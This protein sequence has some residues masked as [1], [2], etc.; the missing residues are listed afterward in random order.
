LLVPLSSLRSGGI[1]WGNTC[2][3]APSGSV[4]VRDRVRVGCFVSPL[5][6]WCVACTTRLRAPS[7]CTTV[8]GSGIERFASETR[9]LR[10]TR[11]RA[12]IIARVFSSGWVTCNIAHV[13]E[14]TSIVAR[15]I[16]ATRCG[17]CSSRS[18]LVR[19][20]AQILVRGGRSGGYSRDVAVGE[21]YPGG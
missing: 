18:A 13:D 11:T 3:R 5:R 17:R 16:D 21:V 8:S 15:V 7:G 2:L 9:S 12:C 19:Q 6:G 20:R 10:S 4:R 14:R 1:V